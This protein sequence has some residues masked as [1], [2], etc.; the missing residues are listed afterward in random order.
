MLNKNILNFFGRDELNLGEFHSRL[1]KKGLITFGTVLIML[2]WGLFLFQAEKNKKELLNGL[3]REQKNLVSVLAENLY[4]ILEQRQTIELFA[5]KW[6]N[7]TK[8]P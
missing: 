5:S 6:F 3:K 4:Q 7:G 8:Q 1:L 2:A